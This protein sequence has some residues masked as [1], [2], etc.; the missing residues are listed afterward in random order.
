LKTNRDEKGPP[1]RPEVLVRGWNK[2]AEAQ[3]SFD[4]LQQGLPYRTSIPTK[5]GIIDNIIQ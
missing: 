2:G 3:V 1:F 5:A 4:G